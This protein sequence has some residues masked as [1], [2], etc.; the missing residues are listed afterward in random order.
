[1]VHYMLKYQLQQ[2]YKVRSK[3]SQIFNTHQLR[4]KIKEYSEEPEDDNKAFIAVSEVID[5]DEDK[6]PKFHILWTSKTLKK[7]IDQK[8]LIRTPKR[9]N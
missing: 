4:E 2:Q 7:R 6:E 3:S 8:L 1:M 9:P 5:E